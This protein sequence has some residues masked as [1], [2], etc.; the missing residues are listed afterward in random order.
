[1]RSYLGKGFA[2]AGDLA[3]SARELDY[4]KRLDLNDPTPWLYSA[5]LNRDETRFNDGIKDLE[6]SAGLNDNRMVY[7]SRFLLDQDRAVRSTSLATI[8]RDAGMTDVAYREATKAVSYDYANYSAHL[9]LANSLESL[10][11]PTRFNL[12][13]ETAWFNELLLANALSPAMAGVFSQNISQQEYSQLFENK[14][15]G[16]TSTTEVRSDSQVRETASQ[17][18][19]FGDFSYSLDVDYQHN[20]ETGQNGRPNNELG[21]LEFYGQFK[22]QLTPQDSFFVLTKYQDYHSG[23]NFQYYDWQVSVRTNFTFDETQSPIVVG[24]YRHEW[25]PGIQ[26]MLLGGRLENEQHF[27]DEDAPLFVRLGN[28]PLV[29]LQAVPTVVNLRP[30]RLNLT[31]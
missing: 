10:R 7:R 13:Y 14:K 21:R 1:L 23:D 18:G 2:D 4:A 5:L 16:L 6:K 20:P 11:D 3:L 22:F 25:S 8:Y 24:V 26:T 30:I 12:R 9:F 28:T 31:R 29:D 19:N 15:L 17:F 27:N